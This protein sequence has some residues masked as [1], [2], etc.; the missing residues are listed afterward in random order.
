[1]FLGLSLKLKENK[2]FICGGMMPQVGE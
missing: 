1:M 2:L